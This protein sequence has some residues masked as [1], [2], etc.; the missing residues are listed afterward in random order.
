MAKLTDYIESS[1]FD[2][3]DILIK[4]GLS[5]TRK[6]KVANAAV[7]FA[8]LS[9]V[10]TTSA[11]GLMSKEDKLKLDN[12]V[13]G[14]PR[15]WTH[16]KH[17]ALSGTG[18]DETDY[19]MKFYL[20][21]G[22]Q[23]GDLSGNDV[24]M[25]GQCKTDFSDIRFMD[26]VGNPLSHY[27]HTYGNYEV[28]IDSR[29]YK[30]NIIN[31]GIIYASNSN[32]ADG[33]LKSADNGQSWEKI[34]SS[35][36]TY[37]KVIL[38]DSRGYIY[39]LE[40]S[41]L[42]RSTDSGATFGTVLDMSS[43]IGAS[44]EYYGI[45]EDA[46]GDIYIGRYQ[47]AYDATILKSTD[48][49]A[50]FSVVWNDNT[51]Q[52]IHGVDIDPFT[53]YVY[54]GV[55]GAVPMLIR[56]VDDGATWTTVYNGKGA[57]VS[58]FAFT[59]TKRFFAGGAKFKEHGA[60]ILMTSDD[61]NF[62]S[63]LNTD[64]SVQ[65]MKIL[66]N[67][68]YAA[69]TAFE[70]NGY[71]QLYQIALDGSNAKTISVCP[72][73]LTGSFSGY[74]NINDAGTPTASINRQLLIGSVNVVGGI[75][76]PNLRVFDGGTHHQ[77]TFFV[78]I[79]NLPAGGTSIYVCSGNPSATSVG[80]ITLFDDIVQPNLLGRW[81]FN[82]GSGTTIQDLSGNDRHGSLVHVAGKGSWNEFSG[83][84][85]GAVY[86]FI[87][88]AGH[89]YNFNGGDY[90]EIPNDAVLDA[91]IKGFS[92]VAWIKDNSTS[93]AQRAVIS[94]GVGNNGWALHTRGGTA[95]PVL[96]YGNGSA[97]TY[98]I[99]S[100]SCQKM[101]HMVGFTLDTSTPAKISTIYD[102]K[103]FSTTALLYDIIANTGLP[104]RIG[105]ASDG[106]EL[107]IGDIDEIQLYQ[108]ALT[109]L[110]VQQLY[111]NRFLATTEPQIL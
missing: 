7:E 67:Y 69:G 92:V 43:V 60:T 99:Y 81:K 74:S 76:H 45:K 44:I 52:H 11:N 10:A 26:S 77:A 49:G 41:V 109:A 78:K 102:G 58:V 40:D 15:T 48:Q 9:P 61:V 100:W 93:S 103:L 106:S 3:G 39:I 105:A 68:L 72:L 17:I 107:F 64:Q 27:R 66:G 24:F 57:D 97:N 89:S 63:I 6:I 62:T 84:R 101:W 22:N 21:W 20:H 47:P 2:S 104:L 28:V 4:D 5:G 65:G 32:G 79:P 54:A 91:L 73:D 56:S 94:K 30:Y 42:K 36:A 70:P 71:S 59:A 86:P 46:K 25:N 34:Y 96:N 8:Q 83:R 33:I 85:S 38:V 51:Y 108:G 110:Q 29:L 37:L 50:S 31:N 98:G 75:K 14:L 90:V 23:E 12:L 82:E 87:V 88:Q 18:Q 80:D 55:D 95:Y 19:I 16:Q 53:G 13:A 35:V 1:H 111:E